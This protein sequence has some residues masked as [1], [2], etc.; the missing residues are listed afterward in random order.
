MLKYP[1]ELPELPYEY[2]ALEPFIDSETMHYHHDKHFKTYIDNLNKALEPY[3]QLQKMPLE[4][5]LMNPFRI[6][7]E[8]RTFLMNNAGGVY[9]H[10]LFF[11]NLTPE[12]EKNQP[13][14][15]L[16]SMIEKQFGSMENLKKIFIENAESV[17]GSGY[18]FL[19]MA[20]NGMLKII[21][22]ANQDTVLMF[23]VMPVILVDV[24]EHAYY[25]KYKNLRKEYLENIF[26][27]INWQAFFN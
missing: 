12:K 8:I 7:P 17:F 21:N 10:Y 9:N 1:Y 26:N 13:T 2:D 25:L 24:W 27:V 15:K 11:N 6:P 22:T 20:Q 4:W 14:T 16:S 18:T 3:P 23:N 5:L 19:T